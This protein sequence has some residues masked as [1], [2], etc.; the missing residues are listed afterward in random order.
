MY[1]DQ[2]LYTFLTALVTSVIA[3][4]GNK[5]DKFSKAKEKREVVRDCV[6]GVEQLYPD[7]TG[8]EKYQEAVSAAR[9]I[10]RNKG[11]AVTDL[12]IKMMI[13]SKCQEFNKDRSKAKG[14]HERH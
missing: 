13:E 11:I 6:Q 3:W 9:E 7:L 2:I 10:L 1:G 14:R 12:E 8:E 4:F 5:Y